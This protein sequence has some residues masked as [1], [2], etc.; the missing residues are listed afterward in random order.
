MSDMHHLHEG[1]SHPS[2]TG[3]CHLRITKTKVDLTQILVE[4]GKY[5]FLVPKT[6]YQS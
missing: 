3:T 5:D 4:R 2:Q 1:I 6:F